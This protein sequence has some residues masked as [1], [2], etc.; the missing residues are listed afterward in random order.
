MRVKR[1]SPKTRR[2]DRLASIK[3]KIA[4]RDSLVKSRSRSEPKDDQVAG[5]HNQAVV[6]SPNTLRSGRYYGSSKGAGLK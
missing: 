2:L 3:L 6:E 5:N 1:K 4:E